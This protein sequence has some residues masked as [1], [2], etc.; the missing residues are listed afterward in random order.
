M[1]NFAVVFLAL[2][3]AVPAL[4]DNCR[5]ANPIPVSGSL[6]DRDLLLS[7]STF[8]QTPAWTD[9]SAFDP[10][11]DKIN[12]GLF[13]II[14]G[15]TRTNYLGVS[16]ELEGKAET[17][18]FSGYYDGNFNFQGSTSSSG[19][20]TVYTTKNV[21]NFTEAQHAKND[22][23]TQSVVTV[24]NGNLVSVQLTFPIFKTWKVDANGTHYLAFTGNHQ[25]LCLKS[26]Q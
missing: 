21:R 7:N 6:L 12:V 24:E 3:I 17:I 13:N 9:P 16:V 8:D 10:S 1:K 11:K 2:A 19:N 5:L 15:T 23:I 4:A 18:G 26:A 22:A 25:T 20:T 14:H